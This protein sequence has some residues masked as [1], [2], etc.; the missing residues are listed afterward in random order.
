MHLRVLHTKTNRSVHPATCHS[1]IFP[2]HPPWGR[3]N[4]YVDRTERFVTHL[5]T[6]LKFQDCVSKNIADSFQTNNTKPFKIPEAKNSEQ[7]KNCFFEITVAEWNTLDNEAVHAGF[8]D[9]FKAQHK[10]NI[11]KDWECPPLFICRKALQRLPRI[12]DLGNIQ[13]QRFR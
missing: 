4:T 12:Q 10:K 2:P 11:S 7:Y 5:V 13:I 6:C 9:A 3:L 1:F 8:V